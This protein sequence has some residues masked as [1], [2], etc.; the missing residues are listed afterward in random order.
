MRLDTVGCRKDAAVLL[1]LLAIPTVLTADVIFLGNTFFYRDLTRFFYGS[2]HVFREIVLSR[3]IPLWNPFFSGGQPMAANPEFSVFYP[4]RWLVLL[5][6]FR[7]GFNL[8]LIAHLHLAIVG[9]YLLLRSLRLAIPSAS[10]G[11]LAF[12]IGGFTCSYMNIPP[13][14]FTLAW[15]P[16]VLLFGRRLLKRPTPADFALTALCLGIQQLA[17]EPTTILQTG[18]LLGALFIYYLV[19]EPSGRRVRFLLLRGGVLGAAVVAG[20]LAGAAQLF[21]TIDFVRD[22]VR[23]EGLPFDVVK[24]WSMP[25][26]RVLELFFPAFLGHKADAG[27]LYWGVAAYKAREGPYILGLYVGYL[28]PLLALSGIVTRQKG[29]ALCASLM[30]ISYLL[31]LG[32]HT[33]LLRFLYDSGMFRAFRYPEKFVLLG[34]VALI[35]QSAVFLDRLI[36]GDRKAIRAVL[37]VGAVPAAISAGAWA[38]TFT[39]GYVEWLRSYWSVP[40]DELAR[41]IAAATRADWMVAAIR[42]MV[43]LL[44]VGSLLKLRVNRAWLGVLALVVIYDLG[45]TANRD[46]PRFTRRF[47]D[48]P[49]AVEDMK[50]RGTARLFHEADVRENHFSAPAPGR[51]EQRYWILRDGLYPKLPALWSVPTVLEP[52]YDLTQLEPTRNLYTAM[53]VAGKIRGGKIPEVFRKISNVGTIAR[54]SDVS[55]SSPIEFEPVGPYPRYYFASRLVRVGDLREFIQAVATDDWRDTDAFVDFD[56]SAAPSVGEVRAVQERFNSIDLDVHV[57]GPAFLVIGMTPHRYWGATVDGKPARLLPANIGYQG[58]LLRPG[59]RRV[60]LRYSN[61]VINIGAVVSVFVIAALLL[62]VFI[63]RK[64]L[65]LM[66]A[67]R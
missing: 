31:A 52:D 21:A 66:T 42:G 12:G 24:R 4:I 61:P 15:V 6:S 7:L 18:I 57:K 3:E 44:L 28:T 30:A 56:V 20:L 55:G 37:I 40:T 51:G 43:A 1:L 63:D 23:A 5:P 14:L 10:F 41:M 32:D 17:G 35:V 36:A 60:S 48:P 27:F 33:P 9:M 53:V 54:H 46:L 47:F 38:F 58:L 62:T 29:A 67:S 45:T 49:A 64:Q 39:H 50:R 16:F 13:F 8:Q 2:D 65:R 25:P 11:A 59:A 19:R 26:S 22:T 34:M